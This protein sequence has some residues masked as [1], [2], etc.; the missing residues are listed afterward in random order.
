V[1]SMLLRRAELAD[2]RRLPRR[3]ATAC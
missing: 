2:V 1:W 3:Q